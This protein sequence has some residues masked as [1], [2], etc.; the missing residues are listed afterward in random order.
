MSVS[1]EEGILL[2]VYEVYTEF[3]SCFPN[4]FEDVVFSETEFR[5]AICQY[6]EERAIPRLFYK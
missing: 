6:L 2:D 5:K 1:L 3:V 4:I